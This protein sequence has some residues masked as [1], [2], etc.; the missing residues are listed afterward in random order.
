[1]YIINTIRFKIIILD[2]VIIKEI[3]DRTNDVTGQSCDVV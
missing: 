1:M 2:T 3:T